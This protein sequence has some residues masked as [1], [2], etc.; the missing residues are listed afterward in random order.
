MKVIPGFRTA[1]QDATQRSPLAFLLHVSLI[2]G[3]LSRHVYLPTCSNA[4]L[5]RYLS[6]LTFVIRY[7]YSLGKA[8]YNLSVNTD[9]SHFKF[10]GLVSLLPI[11]CHSEFTSSISRPGFY[12]S[13]TTVSALLPAAAQGSRGISLISNLTLLVWENFSILPV[14]RMR[15]DVF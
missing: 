2:L 6:I 14:F 10:H 1:L 4:R 7:L 12:A 5:N 8:F 15:T 3:S 9:S 13:G 11:K